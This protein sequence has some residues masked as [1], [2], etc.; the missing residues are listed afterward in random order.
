MG[1]PYVG[2]EN[3]QDNLFLP[4]PAGAPRPAFLAPQAQAAGDLSR[5]EPL[6]I[7]GFEGMRDFY[8]LLI[9]ENLTKLGYPARA[10]M[11]PMAL[12]TDRRD[13]NTVPSGSRAG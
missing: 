7:V 10:E 8:P 13:A 3:G 5:Q 9:A 11:L 4:S 2:A 12:I 6:L 1:V